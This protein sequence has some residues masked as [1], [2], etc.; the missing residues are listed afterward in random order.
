MN[1]AIYNTLEEYQDKVNSINTFLG[2]PNDRGTGTY[3]PLDIEPTD[4]TEVDEEGNEILV[5][6][7]YLVPITDK[8][9]HLFH[10]HVEFTDGYAKIVTKKVVVKPV[11]VLI[12]VKTFVE[13]LTS[14]N[15][16]I[17]AIVQYCNSAG[18][19]E[20]ELN[21]AFYEGY[22]LDNVLP[23]QIYLEYIYSAHADI[24]IRYGAVI[25]Y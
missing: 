10:D 16:E 15:P 14:D 2:Y 25:E 3:A 12:P 13:W 7:I 18:I 22:D 4:I 24:L 17:Q 19:S 6:Q 8:V 11:R 5:K 21:P 20:A 1:Q 23:K 9:L